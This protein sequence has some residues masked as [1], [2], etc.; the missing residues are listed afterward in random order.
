M[1]GDDTEVYL[2]GLMVEFE[3][4]RMDV[5]ASGK[6]HLHMKPKREWATQYVSLMWPAGY[7]RSVDVVTKRDDVTDRVT[8]KGPCWVEDDVIH[9]SGDPREP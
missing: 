9:W 5:E 7:R 3:E 4:L 1:M 8:A 6:V 2:D